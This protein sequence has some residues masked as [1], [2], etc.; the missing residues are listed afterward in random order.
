MKQG[1]VIESNKE[2]H[3]YREAISKSG[4]AN[5]SLCPQ[6]FK[7]CEENPKEPTDDLIIGSAF[8]KIVLEPDD[9]ENEFIVSPTF[10][11]RTKEGK[12]AYNDFVEKVEDKALRVINQE[13]YEMICGMRD[14]ILSNPYASALIKGNVEQSFYFTDDLTGEQVK[15]R[16][17]VWRKV[18]DRV[19]ITDLKSCKSAL[20]KDV[21]KDVVNYHYNLQDAMYR[22]AVN[23]V[24]GTPLEN[25]DFVFIFV[26]KKPPYLLN[27]VVSTQA[28]FDSGDADFRK[29]IGEYHECKQS[30]VWYGLNGA[31][32][33]PNELNLPKYMT[34]KG[35]KE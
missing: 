14:S 29:W 11:R 1:I 25:I 15:A 22:T 5:M 12:A 2:Y 27:I 18:Q 35:D 4:L 17:D 7:W 31:Y 24:L 30:G 32:G 23:K 3:G 33:I 26:E 8:H 13:Q 6:Y 16:P 10:D 21:A 19:A 9:F 20:P 28:I 34:E